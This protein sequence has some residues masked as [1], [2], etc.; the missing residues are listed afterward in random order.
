M[1]KKQKGHKAENDLAKA[2][3][4]QGYAVQ[5]AQRTSVFTGKFYVSRDN[6]FFNLFDL[7]AI[8]KSKIL[9]V[10][11]KTNVNHIYGVNKKISDFANKY[12]NINVKYISALKVPRKGWVFWFYNPYYKEFSKYSKEF[13]KLFFNLKLDMVEP[14][15]YS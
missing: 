15:K 2:F 12:N 10:Q 5:V 6:D 9:L 14:F 8:D 7:L 13:N 1:N 11:V 4:N 3:R